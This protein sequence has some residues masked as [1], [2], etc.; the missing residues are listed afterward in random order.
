MQ[1]YR[2]YT[3]AFL[4]LSSSVQSAELLEPEGI[5]SAEGRIFPEFTLEEFYNDN[6]INA[7]SN[8][9]DTFGT[10]VQPK[11]GFEFE[12]STGFLFGEYEISAAAHEASSQDDYV[13]Q[14]AQLGFQYSPT[15]RI[16]LGLSGEYL[17]THDAR[18]TGAA[19]GTGAVQTNPDEWR[20]LKFDGNFSY[21]AESAKGRF[22]LDAGFIN[23][24]YENNRST[25]AVRDREDTYGSGRFYYR[26]MPKTSL[27][28]EGRAINFNYD[29]DSVGSASLDSTTSR[30]LFGVTWEG[31]YK[32]TGTAQIGYIRKDFD[33]DARST[34]ED[35][36]WEFGVEWQPRTYS[37]VTLNT[38]RDFNE[39]NGTG[40]FIITD[41][42]DLGW[43]HNWTDRIRTTL[44]FRYAEDSFDQDTTG[45]EDEK[46]AF[47]A[48]IIYELRNWVEIGAGYDYDER[49]S[50]DNTFDYEKNI[51]NIF[52]T[53]AF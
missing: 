11:I 15:S 42:I 6:L 3:L 40:N 52:A 4:L 27:L 28:L 25:T 36:S 53:I 30:V 39:T 13:D 43:S 26:L 1:F 45:R 32:T 2:N 5:K 7:A 49:E 9:I 34:G 16:S 19:E 14:S 37:T 41:S 18:G 8:E 46:L 50:N 47:G 23:K 33:A 10:F 44:S 29:T 20:H 12:G 51:A 31:T 38:S 48:N 17:D 22:E 21:G 35:I 24:D